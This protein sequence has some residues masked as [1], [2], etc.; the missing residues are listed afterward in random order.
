[1]IVYLCR[2]Y[3]LKSYYPLLPLLH[4][5][6]HS[7]CL[8]LH[9]CSANTFISIIFLDSI[10]TCVCYYAIFVFLFLSASLC[11]TG[12]RFFHLTATD[13]YLFHFIL[14]NIPLC[15]RTTASYPFIYQWTPW[16]LPRPGY[17]KRCCNEH[18]GTC[19]FW[20]LVFPRYIPSSRIVEYMVVL[21]LGFMEK[22]F[23]K[24]IQTTE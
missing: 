2:C 18:C 4:P 17:C 5:Q 12:C 7:L 11:I 6:V 21:I 14:S 8:H 22:H 9:S 1:M 19:A 23:L 13:S 15:I 16:L 20:I 3:F 24:L 10:Y